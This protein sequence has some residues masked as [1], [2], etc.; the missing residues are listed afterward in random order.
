MLRLLIKDITVERTT[1]LRQALLHIRWQ[2]GACETIAV[3]LPPRI[4]DRIRYPAEVVERVRRLAETQNNEQIAR[5][6]NGEGLLSAKGKRFTVSMIA[7]IRYR[8]RIPS[9]QLKR[10]EEQTVEQIAERFAVSRYVVYYWIERGVLEARRENNGSP[11]W[12]TL[13]SD[14]ETE[15]AN[16]VRNSSK[17][18]RNA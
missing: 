4:Q 14:K 1:E 13:D 10:P 9:P 11:Y 2:G 16:W 6:L 8:H 17:I 5:T 12:I 15:L 7:W 3:A 18:R